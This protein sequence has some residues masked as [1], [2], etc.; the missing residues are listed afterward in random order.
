MMTNEYGLDYAY[1]KKKLLEM[2]RDCGNY[3]PGKMRRLLYMY[4]KVAD[5]YGFGISGWYGITGS[6]GD[7]TTQT[8]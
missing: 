2:A 6:L 4:A 7:G 1:F 5:V 8:A 3:T